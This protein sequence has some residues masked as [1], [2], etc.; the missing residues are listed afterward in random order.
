LTLGGC[1]DGHAEAEGI[2]VGQ[3]AGKRRKIKLPKDFTPPTLRVLILLYEKSDQT[4]HF[5]VD[6]V[7]RL[8]A[9]GHAAGFASKT[10][11][12]LHMNVGR[13]SKYVSGQGAD[14]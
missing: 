4:R 8:Q 12:E 10:L 14:A 13:V 7:Y 2:L 6:L 5:M 1:V 9:R 11:E 3:G